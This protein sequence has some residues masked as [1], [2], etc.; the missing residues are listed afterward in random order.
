MLSTQML[1]AKIKK[2][3]FMRLRTTDLSSCCF[4]KLPIVHKPE[5]CWIQSM[6]KDA[7]ANAIRPCTCVQS[8]AS[9]T[10]ACVHSMREDDVIRRGQTSL[11]RTI[12]VVAWMM[13]Q[14]LTLNLHEQSHPYWLHQTPTLATTGALRPRRSAWMPPEQNLQNRK[15]SER[16]AKN[17]TCC[18]NLVQ[19]LPSERHLCA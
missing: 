18:L 5:E 15:D 11:A 2:F 6:R 3:E 13:S 19:L 1:A 16:T 10:H 9:T 4:T 7:H 12:S 8:W 14:V 17:G